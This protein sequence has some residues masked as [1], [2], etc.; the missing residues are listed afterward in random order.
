MTEKG[1]GSMDNERLQIWLNFSKFILGSVVLGSI[2]LMVNSRIQE[3]EV[4]IK[5]MEQLGTFVDKAIDDSV[6]IRRRFAKYFSTVTRS[7]E[8]RGRWEIYAAAIEAEFEEK[9]EAKNKL[10]AEKADLT[11]KL[12]TLVTKSKEEKKERAA[13]EAKLSRVEGRLAVVQN[14]LTQSNKPDR[15]EETTTRRGPGWSLK[16]IGGT[17]FDPDGTDDSIHLQ[18]IITGGKRNAAIIDNEVFHVGDIIHG[19][20]I[21]E[22]TPNGVSFRYRGRTIKEQLKR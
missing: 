16:K 19:A 15:S 2:T 18:G 6:Y 8:I 20:K 21:I 11:A 3:R 10:D 17:S 4:E 22:I 14:D 7:K 12:N 9:E 5:E 13:I 1:V